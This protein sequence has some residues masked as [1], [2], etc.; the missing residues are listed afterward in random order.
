VSFLRTSIIIESLPPGGNEGD[1]ADD[2]E[3][4][5]IR[6]RLIDEEPALVICGVTPATTVLLR[7]MVR[8]MGSSN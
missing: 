2:D 1:E 8:T 5:E 7:Y 6:A 4:D 3:I